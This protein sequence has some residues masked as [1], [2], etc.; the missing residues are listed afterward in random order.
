MSDVKSDSEVIAE[1]AEEFVSRYREGERPPVSEYTRQHPELAEQIREFFGAVAMVENLAPAESESFGDAD[2][3]SSPEA[4]LPELK[5]LGD[6][7]IIREVGRGGMG[8]VYEA[9]Q[10]SLG[11]HV[12]LKVLP[13]AALPDSKHVRRFEREAKSAAK[14]HH[15]NIVPVFGVGEQEGLHYYVMQFIQGLPLDEVILELK[16]IQKQPTGAITAAVSHQGDESPRR[17]CSAA[18]VARSL[19]T[20]QF[21]QPDAESGSSGDS[22]QPP[23]AAMFAL[24]ELTPRSEDTASARLSDTLNLSGSFS[25]SVSRL[26]TSGVHSSSQRKI[27]TYWQSVATIGQQVA[28]AMQYA[29]EQGILHRD[30]KPSNLLLDL[31][32]TTWVTD[33]GLAKATDQQDITHTGD[34]LGTLRY[35][36][37]EAFEGK[38]DA[39]GDVYSLGLT[40]YELLAFEPAFNKRDRH[41]LIKQVTSESPQRLD[42]LNPA[43]PRDLVTIVHKAIERDA[44]HR[45]QSAEE[46]SEDLQ[47]FVED[48]PIKARRISVVER[49]SRWS[50]RNKALA[51]SLITIAGLVLVGL[52]GST[53]AAGYFRQEQHKTAI[54]RDNAKAA[55]A[56]ADQARDAQE[57]LRIAADLDRQNAV[58]ARESALVAQQQTQRSLYFANIQMA[59]AALASGN[60]ERQQDLLAPWSPMDADAH[61]LRSFEWYYLL[62][63]NALDHQVL[64]GHTHDVRSIAW[65]P[66]G[67]RVA[68][69]ARDDTMRIWDAETGQLL[70]TIEN[71]GSIWALAWSP[72][73]DRLASVS[74]PEL[75]IWD[76]ETGQD[77]ATFHAHENFVADVVWSP[78]GQRLASACWDKTVR[79]WDVETEQ[80]LAVLE[81]PKRLWCTAWHPDGRRLATGAFDEGIIRVWDTE[82][83]EV[84]ET[85]DGGTDRTPALA[86]HRDG[87]RLVSSG[88]DGEVFLWEVGRERPLRQFSGHETGHWVNEVIWSP[89]DADRL[90]TVSGDKSIRLWDAEAGTNTQTLL[91]HTGWVDSGCWSPDGQKIATGGNDHTVRIWD[92]ASS[93]DEDHPDDHAAHSSAVAWSPDGSRYATGSMGATIRIWRSGDRELLHVLEDPEERQDRTQ[94]LQFSPDGRRLASGGHDGFVRIWDAEDGRLLHRFGQHGVNPFNAQY[95]G[96]RSLAWHPGG[97]LL[98][99]A[100]V[101]PEIRVWDVTAGEQ[102]ATI[103]AEGPT[104]SVSLTPD[105]AFLATGHT[106]KNRIGLWETETWSRVGRLDP[107]DVYTRCVQFAPDGTKLAAACGRGRN[108]KDPLSQEYG[109]ILVW[110]WRTSPQQQDAQPLVEIDG[111]IGQVLKLCWTPDGKRL[112]TS[113]SDG[114]ARLWD[115]TGSGNSGFDQ[116]LLRFESPNHWNAALRFSPDGSRLAL[117]TDKAVSFIDAYNGYARER[118]PQLLRTLAARIAAGTASEDDYK[119]QAE[120]DTTRGKWAAAAEAYAELANLGSTT[121]C[122]IAG[123]WG[124]GHFPGDL[125]RPFAPETVDDGDAFK[126]DEELPTAEGT[127][128]WRRV[129]VEPGTPLDFGE[130]FGRRENVTAYAVYRVFSPIRQEVGVLLGDD[131]D[132]R[133][134]LN[135]Q[136]VSERTRSGMLTPDEHVIG[137]TLASGWNTLLAKVLNRKNNHGLQLRISDDPVVLAS[138]YER[139]EQFEAALRMWDVAIEAR[140]NDLTLLLKRG[141]TRFKQRDLDGADVDFAAFLNGREEDA[142]ALDR[143]GRAY[144]DLGRVDKGLADYRRAVELTPESLKRRHRC[145]FAALNWNRPKLAA[146]QLDALIERLPDEDSIFFLRTPLYLINGDEKGYR[147]FRESFVRRFQETTDPSEAARIV[148][149]SLLLPAD[150]D[151]LAVCARLGAVAAASDEIH[152]FHW[153]HVVADGLA[154][155]RMGGLAESQ[156]NRDEARSHFEAARSSLEAALAG[157][158][159]DDFPSKHTQGMFLLAGTLYSLGEDA[160]ARRT[161]K[162]ADGEYRQLPAEYNDHMPEVYMARILRSEATSLILGPDVEKIQQA[163]L[164]LSE[165]DHEA[166]AEAFVEILSTPTLSELLPNGIEAITSQPESNRSFWIDVLTRVI[167]ANP[168]S[169]Q[170]VK[171]RSQLYVVSERYLE[172]GQDYARWAPIAETEGIHWLSTASLLALSGNET[173]YREYCESLVE[174]NGDVTHFQKASRLTKACSLLPRVIDPAQLPVEAMVAELQSG[175]ADP[176]WERWAYGARAL[177]AYRAGDLETAITSANKG[178]ELVRAIDSDFTKRGVTSLVSPLQAIIEYHHTGSAKRAGQFLAVGKDAVDQSLERHPDGRIVGGSLFNRQGKLR[179]NEIIGELLRREAEEYIR[180]GSGGR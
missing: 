69:G 125:E 3:E 40:M 148:T 10:V 122:T 137:V 142:A 22:S 109:K 173:A 120:I 158:A 138:A 111:T 85:F 84:V 2:A 9:E 166:A 75:I 175:S 178:E 119:L 95:R 20:G 143:R 139:T 106:P 99:S 150:E 155:Y 62:S 76:G 51:A 117:T 132:H 50:R 126:V 52:I 90:L 115:V 171:R 41:Q 105:G 54:E 164:L 146:E 32:G 28:D 133:L 154:K 91:G 14:L 39:R 112:A 135:N 65:H 23:D 93:G 167:D 47:R 89:V 87:E 100:G 56:E 80:Q 127:T 64:Q 1:L 36:P 60:Y 165:G 168:D 35:M 160:A 172:A 96:V 27:S 110:D 179:N 48:E 46:L 113:S 169:L 101:D 134:W 73:G 162:A 124:A 30:I 4:T 145:T 151:L 49:F 129:E 102:V 94:D 59:N 25:G 71:D 58:D 31:R 149:P 123:I 34:V 53:V 44:A 57:Q 37:P 55:R 128:R 77:L 24:T 121:R 21:P 67:T 12:A 97:T 118:S 29:H 177:A 114:T 74:G 86:W 26:T 16:K 157:L 45:Y 13:A 161:L 130:L 63:Q 6:F 103:D 81:H 42:R 7:R 19:M 144:L 68:S 104:H 174:T 88:D 159:S 92:V 107:G 153:F 170:L 38:S 131:D 116:E 176:N 98:I 163:E 5:Q 152:N 82:A 18:D 43:I 156:G 108:N 141:S 79:I 8:V 147:E 15:T 61:D 70:R 180:T 140:P 33:F 78:D 11:R 83:K 136:L 17:D 66:D 72:E